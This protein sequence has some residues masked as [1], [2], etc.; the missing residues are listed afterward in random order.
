[1]QKTKLLSLLFLLTI[2]QILYAQNKNNIA[3][4]YGLSDNAYISAMDGSASYNGEGA[5]LFEITY[6]RKLNKRFALQGGLVYS[7]NKFTISPAPTGYEIAS[8][9]NEIEMLSIPVYANFTF[10]KYF[11]INGALITD[12]E[13]NR[14]EFESTDNQSGFGFGSGIGFRYAYKQVGVFINPFLNIHSLI[15]FQKDSYQQ[16]LAEAGIKFGLF[17]SF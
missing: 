17:Y 6:Y 7:Q 2:S 5:K 10:G 8:Y 4:S 16:H 15:H 3:I 9:K 14:K 12:F 1:M 13:L 11:F